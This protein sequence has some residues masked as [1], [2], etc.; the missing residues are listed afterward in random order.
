MSQ[1]DYDL[2]TI[3][4]GSGG[5][6]ASRVAAG[7]GA[8]VALIEEHRLGGTCVN[9]GCIPK[10]LFSYAAH[11]AHDFEEAS[12]FGWNAGSCT[13][14]WAA[15]V[16]GKNREI[17]RLNGV[18]AR[19]LAEAGV[20]VIEARATLVD[21]HTV[22]AGGQTLTARYIL[23]ATGGRP[24]VPEIPG[25]Q[26]AITSNEA[27]HLEH[28]P[29]RIVVVGGGYIAVEFASI[30][31][32]LGC[33]VTLVHRGAQLLR[34]FDPD[35]GKVL[36]EE[37]THHGVEFAFDST[38]ERIERVKAG[39][40]VRLASGGRRETDLI[41][42]ATGRMPNTRGLGLEEAGV[43]LAD[44]GAIRVD[45]GFRSNVPSVFAIGDAIDRVQLTPVATAE[46]T[47]LAGA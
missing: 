3:G 37:M 14:D 34:G 43:A 11:Y 15:L 23:V 19:L 8:R 28:L 17:A 4:G 47:L 40:A 2:I 21:A 13:F 1:Y 9:A 27:F 25:A 35:L 20:T 44:N 16:A 26:H 12:G 10:K 39:Y 6:R 36:A 33:D 29:P 5:V 42:F 38:I 24:M 31:R 18:Y 46:G 7:Y 45:D 30:F 41:L 32:G 22:R